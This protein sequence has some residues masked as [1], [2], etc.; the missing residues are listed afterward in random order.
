MQGFQKSAK[1]FNKTVTTE[2]AEP[3]LR[4]GLQF[5]IDA[6][7]DLDTERCHAMGW[8]RIPWHAV[9]QYGTA[10]RLNSEQM[11]DLVTFI[12]RMDVAHIARLDEKR[13]AERAQKGN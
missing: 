12:A 1:R 13:Q 4:Y 7:L 5:Y 8:Q 9:W 11:D 6:F 3:K 10:H 2:Q